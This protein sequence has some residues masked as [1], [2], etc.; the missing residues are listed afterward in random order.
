MLEIDFS[1]FFDELDVVKAA[2]SQPAKSKKRKKNSKIQNIHIGDPRRL[3]HLPN[4]VNEDFLV[5]YKDTLDALLYP[6]VA[7]GK[8][9]VSYAHRYAQAIMDNVF[10]TEKHLGI[11]HYLQD[12]NV[13]GLSG[14]DLVNHAEKLLMRGWHVK[15]E[16]TRYW[17][18]NGDLQKIID[19]TGNGEVSVL[20]ESQSFD[21]TNAHLFFEEST[22]AKINAFAERLGYDADT[23]SLTSSLDILLNKTENK[24]F[25][26]YLTNYERLRV[27]L[28]KQYK[29][30]TLTDGLSM[31][32]LYSEGYRI[33]PTLVPNG[34]VLKREGE[35]EVIIFPTSDEVNTVH[36]VNK[37]VASQIANEIRQA[38][39]KKLPK[40]N[41]Q[42]TE[43]IKDLRHVFA[44][45]SEL[46]KTDLVTNSYIE[47][48]QI[49]D[50]LDHQVQNRII[51][52]G[53]KNTME[54]ALAM[55]V[56][57][58]SILLGNYWFNLSSLGL[59]SLSG[60]IYVYSTFDVFT[61][62]N[63]QTELE[64]PEE[65]IFKYR[66]NAKDYIDKLPVSYIRA[67]KSIEFPM[68]EYVQEFESIQSYFEDARRYILGEAE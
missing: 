23:L 49:L 30:R 21:T 7:Y 57:T 48:K 41:A 13:E 64:G 34:A 47:N 24:E 55:A 43:P 11:F 10:G 18:Y 22:A 26:G 39:Y 8:V 19:V 67:L 65:T 28:E 25:F 44:Y 2:P 66:S 33:S 40:M 12:K 62:E 27:I 31:Q 17:M 29:Y 58:E 56:V 46:W 5:K 15:E 68:D 1:K 60:N 63:L 14:K 37:S 36:T 45:T 54:Q 3:A 50:R 51:S 32:N 61:R 9:P 35:G 52:E 59:D 16:N 42:Q 53:Y 38:L 20:S 6:Y 4:E